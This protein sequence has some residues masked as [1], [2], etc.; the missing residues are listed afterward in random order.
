M[1]YG[2][3]EFEKYFSDINGA[4]HCTHLGQAV[5]ELALVADDGGDER[6]VLGGVLAAGAQA[7]EAPRRLEVVA[8]VVGAVQLQEGGELLLGVV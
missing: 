8:T 5:A 6:S 1:K 3:P 7:V 2:N 4:I